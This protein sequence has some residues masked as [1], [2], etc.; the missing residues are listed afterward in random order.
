MLVSFID[1]YF[2]N[3]KIL[4]FVLRRKSEVLYRSEFEYYMNNTAQKLN[5]LKILKDRS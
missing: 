4:Y 2:Q 3:N 5:M 1:A